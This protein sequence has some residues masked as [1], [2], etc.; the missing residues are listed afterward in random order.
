[1]LIQTTYYVIILLIVMYNSIIASSVD[2][3]FC[4]LSDEPLG[5]ASLAQCHKGVLKETGET[6]AIKIQHPDVHKN[7]Y[8]DLDTMEVCE[9]L[10]LLVPC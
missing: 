9:A 7:A 5:A 10:A 4:D 6:V 1:M 2:S 8:T 3:V